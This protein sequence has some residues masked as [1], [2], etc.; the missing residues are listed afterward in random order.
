[1]KTNIKAKFN[2]KAKQIKTRRKALRRRYDSWMIPSIW[3]SLV[4]LLMFSTVLPH[5]GENTFEHLRSPLVK[6]A[7]IIALGIWIWFVFEFI[8]FVRAS[9]GMRHFPKQI[10]RGLVVLIFPAFRVAQRSFSRPGKIWLPFMG[11]KKKNKK[12]F[13]KLTHA[14]SVPMI[15]V[16]LLVLPIMA[17]ELFRPVWIEDLP[18]VRNLLGVGQ[19][20]IWLAFAY[21]FVVMIAA[22]FKRVSYCFRHWIDLLIIL[23]PIFLFVVPFL[24]LLPIVRLARL[25]SLAGL[26]QMLRMKRLGLKVFQLLALLASTKQIGKN[27]H[28]RRIEKLHDL[29]DDRED[30][31]EDLREE[32][33]KLQQE[34]AEMDAQDEEIDQDRSGDLEDEGGDYSGRY[35]R[36]KKGALAG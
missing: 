2:T 26:T 22:S 31:L 25:G 7:G 35:E 28:K 30:E 10:R 13:R 11:W 33:A 18:W 16:V 19:Q 17:I 32:L 21:E 9:R 8:L 5:N 24:N 29:I 1:M 12:L 20:F 27:Y 15:C 4:W 6:T 14:F 36:R 3:L 23:L 34:Q